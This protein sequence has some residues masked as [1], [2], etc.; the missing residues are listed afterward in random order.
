MRVASILFLF[1][2]QE[3]VIIFVQVIAVD[4]GELNRLRAY[5]F[6][7]CTA[8]VTGDNVAFFHFIHF[9]I[10]RGFALWT[11]TIARCDSASFREKPA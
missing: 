3:L 8:L 1:L 4:M 7:L 6:K 9:K 5:D 11:I 10:Q 2:F